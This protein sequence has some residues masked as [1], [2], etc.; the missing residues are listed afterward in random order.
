[1]HNVVCPKTHLAFYWYTKPALRTP[2]DCIHIVCGI[3][4]D[5]ARDTDTHTHTHTFTQTQTHTHTRTHTHAHT[6]TQTLHVAAVKVDCCM[7]LNKEESRVHIDDC[8]GQVWPS[9]AVA[10][11]F[12]ALRC[13]RYTQ[14]AHT[15]TKAPSQRERPLTSLRLAQLNTT[16][17]TDGKLAAWTSKA[18]EATV[19]IKTGHKRQLFPN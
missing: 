12:P 18:T 8:A 13:V 1:M 14:Q 5:A 19:R 17:S 11:P 4:S 9:S 6:H 7:G 2:N 15:A 16:P 3:I 10:T